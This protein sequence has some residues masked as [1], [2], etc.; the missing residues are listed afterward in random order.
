LYSKWARN[1]TIK[2]SK[3]YKKIKK[4]G[5][6]AGKHNGFVKLGNS[7]GAKSRRIGHCAELWRKEGTGKRRGKGAREE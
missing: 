2:W 1:S 7:R 4:P 3:N 6:I 5:E